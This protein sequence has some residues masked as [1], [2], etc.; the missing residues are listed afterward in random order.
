MDFNIKKFILE[1]QKKHLLQKPDVV[2]EII[3]K[4]LNKDNLVFTYKI[5]VD[6]L[7]FIEISPILRTKIKLKRNQIITELKKNNIF[8]RDII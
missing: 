1:K 7:S 4:I 6:I 3:S 5:N 2:Y 8:I